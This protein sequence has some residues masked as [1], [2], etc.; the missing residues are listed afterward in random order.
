M[1]AY[2]ITKCICPNCK[3]TGK[4]SLSGVACCYCNGEGKAHRDAA[5]RWADVSWCF[6][7]GGYLAGDYSFDEMRDMEAKAK[8]VAALLGE[9][10]RYRRVPA[11]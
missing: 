8:A 6:A 11:P 10:N 2:R 7:G 9:P 3:G 4:A 1:I 5:L